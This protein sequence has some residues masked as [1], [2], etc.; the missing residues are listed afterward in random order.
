MHCSC[1]D[2]N[3]RYKRNCWT[4]FVGPL[5]NSVH[6]AKTR[7][8]VSVQTI[9]FLKPNLLPHFRLYIA[10]LEAD[11]YRLPNCALQSQSTYKPRIPQC[12]SP[13]RNWNL[14]T[15]DPFSR[16]RVWP[17]PQNQRGGGAHRPAGEGVGSP[18][19]DD[20]RK[21]LAICLLCDNI[22]TCLQLVEG[23]IPDSA[24]A[25]QPAKKS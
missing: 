12:L 15:P 3:S 20:W 16:K 21:S 23:G 14:G 9:C 2:V 18:I 7:D 5:D 1:A 17:S 6:W 22:P 25:L 13:R 10:R 24:A 8:R 19:S 4:N 11:S